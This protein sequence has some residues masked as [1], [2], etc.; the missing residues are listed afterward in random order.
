LTGSLATP[1]L[2]AFYPKSAT[3][4]F[5]VKLRTRTK[6]PLLFAQATEMAGG[7]TCLVTA[8]P[9][10]LA[11]N[12]QTAQFMNERPLTRIKLCVV[13]IWLRARC[14]WRHGARHIRPCCR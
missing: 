6:S 13:Q 1:R 7:G 4:L 10:I 3:T 5:L 2:L 11:G 8:F 12:V 14:L 9:H